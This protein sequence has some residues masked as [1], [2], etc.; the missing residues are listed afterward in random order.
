[1]IVVSTHPNFLCFLERRK[2]ARNFDTIKMVEA[3]SQ[4]GLNT[5][6]FEGDGWLVGPKLVF[7]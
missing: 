6:A 1:M 2:T 4:A 3:A 5:F 7:D